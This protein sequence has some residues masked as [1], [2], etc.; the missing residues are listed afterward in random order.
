MRLRI[1]RMD[2]IVQGPLPGDEGDDLAQPLQSAPARSGRLD[3]APARAKS[4][5]CL[6]HTCEPHFFFCVFIRR[7]VTLL[8]AE[9]PAF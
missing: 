9:S 7:S 8:L 2:E 5:P 3:G 1:T 4:K 6:N